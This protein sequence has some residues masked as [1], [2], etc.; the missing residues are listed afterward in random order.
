[1]GGALSLFLA[2][3]LLLGRCNLWS[4]THDI[5]YWSISTGDRNG[6]SVC[7]CVS[8]TV[9]G[10]VCVCLWQWACVSE[11][12]CLCM[13]AG[14]FVYVCKRVCVFLHACGRVCVSLSPSLFFSYRWVWLTALGSLTP[15]YGGISSKG[16]YSH[17]N[18]NPTGIPSLVAYRFLSVQ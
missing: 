2:L 14:V 13:C 16:N 10:C 11:C 12:V 6:S 9:C 4:V 17:K 15:L 8:M 18:G 1:M 7:V 3:T 5:C